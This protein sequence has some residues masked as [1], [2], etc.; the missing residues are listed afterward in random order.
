MKI[1][2]KLISCH[3]A[4]S[5]TVKQEVK[6]TVIRSPLAFPGLTIQRKENYNREQ[7]QHFFCFFRC[8]FSA[9]KF[10]VTFFFFVTDVRGATTL[11]I[12]TLGITTLGTTTLGLK[13]LFATFS[14]MTF[15]I[16]TLC[17]YAECRIFI[18]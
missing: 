15:S 4:D 16:T 17:H 9:K 7:E 13:G 18:H 6:G 3:T 5:K 8:G 12:T 14:T 1:K 2:T 10:D 11:G